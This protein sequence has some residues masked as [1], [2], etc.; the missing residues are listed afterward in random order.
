MAEPPADSDDSASSDD[1]GTAGWA[2]GQQS[3]RSVRQPA[4]A[5]DPMLFGWLS[6]GGGAA[7]LGDAVGRA[8]HNARVASLAEQIIKDGLVPMRG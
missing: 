7:L 5:P 8:L 4:P 6:E 3:A 2:G 1:G